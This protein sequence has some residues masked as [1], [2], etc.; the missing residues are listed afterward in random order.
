MIYSRQAYF[1]GR[2]STGNIK[3][4]RGREVFEDPRQKEIPG[5][6]NSEEADMKVERLIS[7]PVR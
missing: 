7:Q 4:W 2:K 3:G 5:Q 1:E 6:H